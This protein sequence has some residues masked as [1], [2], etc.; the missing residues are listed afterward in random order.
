MRTLLLCLCLLLAPI[1]AGA[2]ISG[3]SD[4]R[5]QDAKRE[6][7][8]GQKDV[9]ALRRMAKLANEGNLAAQIML[10]LVYQSPM[11]WSLDVRAL[12]SKERRHIYHRIDNSPFGTRWLRV[13][14]ERSALAALLTKT[15]V[16]DWATHATAL[17]DAGFVERAWR[18]ASMPASIDND[19]L[20][21][22]LLL[23]HPNLL[24]YSRASLWTTARRLEKAAR[25]Y[26]TPEEADAYAKFRTELGEPSFAEHVFATSF[27]KA[28]TNANPD[29]HHDN[30]RIRGGA[31][32]HHPELA[33]LAAIVSEVCPQDPAFA[34]GA[35]FR[36][37]SS[38]GLR[39][40]LLSPAPMLISTAEWQASPRFRND[41]LYSLERLGTARDRQMALVPC[42]TK[43]ID[44]ALEGP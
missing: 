35:L 12:S 14:A 30:I 40:R 29:D 7:L 38:S 20:G 44:E 22:L 37:E 16:E 27:G 42:I 4:P 28:I 36:L 10:G 23:S 21:S 24:P 13:S 19:Q 41:I 11:G 33:G 31:L 5:F 25:L 1:A 34:L 26:G 18:A 2:Q 15:E 9:D 32:L 17:A 8:T 43:A 6:F 3:Q 39:F